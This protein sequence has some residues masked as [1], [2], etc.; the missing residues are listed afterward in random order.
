MPVYGGINNLYHHIYISS[1][2]VFE[3]LQPDFWTMPVDREW[4][5]VKWERALNYYIFL[6]RIRR[7]SSSSSSFIGSLLAGYFGARVWSSRAKVWRCLTHRSWSDI[8]R[9][10]KTDYIHQFSSEFFFW[11]FTS[12]THTH[13]FVWYRRPGLHH[14]KYKIESIQFLW[15]RDRRSKIFFFC[16]IFFRYYF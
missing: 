2:L 14:H 8:W 11:P 15:N 13:S 10:K 5:C 7:C 6:F 16:V 1:I 4:Q 9:W 3:K 12:H